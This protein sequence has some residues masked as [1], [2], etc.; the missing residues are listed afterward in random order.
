MIGDVDRSVPLKPQGFSTFPTEN[1]RLCQTAARRPLRRASAGSG[2]R[3][4]CACSPHRRGSE[5]RAVVGAVARSG[6]A[7]RTALPRLCRADRAGERAFSRDDHRP[8]ERHRLGPGRDGASPSCPG[9]DRAAP[10]RPWA[11]TAPR[12]RECPG[13][14]SIV[15]NARTRVSRVPRGLS[16][17]IASSK[18]QTK[19]AT[20][21]SLRRASG[22]SA[23]IVSCATSIRCAGRSS[24]VT[25]YWGLGGIERQICAGRHRGQEFAGGAFLSSCPP[26]G[27]SHWEFSA[28]LINRPARNEG[29]IQDRVN[30]LCYL[31]Q[32]PSLPRA[33]KSRLR[34]VHKTRRTATYTLRHFSGRLRHVHKTRRTATYTLRHFSG[35]CFDLSYLLTSCFSRRRTLHGLFKLQT[36][37]FSQFAT[38]K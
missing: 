23:T 24:A 20:D 38:L 31:R 5:R 2:S 4:A 11:P 17:T 25:L 10:E 19:R 14:G 7:N 33:S 30:C 29:C 18:S 16:A 9:Q 8:H 35:A 13:P 34:H 12:H 3:I 15:E 36:F 37:A 1:P 28:I 22:L 26:W 21:T 32:E 6:G 27:Q